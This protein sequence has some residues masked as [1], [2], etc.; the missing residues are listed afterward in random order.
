MTPT[1]YQ[2]CNSCNT[3]RTHRWAAELVLRCIKCGKDHKVLPHTKAKPVQ[4][5][6][7]FTQQLISG[8]GL[9]KKV[10]TFKQ[11][12]ALLNILKGGAKA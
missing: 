8:E 9:Q 3:E 4:E 7:E 11:P 2:F 5:D 10:H 12:T 1:V 6:A